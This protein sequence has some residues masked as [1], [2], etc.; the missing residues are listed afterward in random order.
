MRHVVTECERVRRGAD[1]LRR[2][3]RNMLGA[4]INASHASSRD[5]YEVTIAELDALQESACAAQGCLGARV[6]G[7][8]FGGGIL[9]VVDQ[10]STAE[11]AER[12][13]ADFAARFDREPRIELLRIAAGAEL[14]EP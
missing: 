6:S 9:A 10:Q 13:R 5:N 1:A 3:D 4:A 14:L 12:L 11:V 8:G 7:A 2:G